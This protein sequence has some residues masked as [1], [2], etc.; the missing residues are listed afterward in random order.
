[1]SK[2]HNQLLQI[3]DV[4]DQIMMQ[5]RILWAKHH[6]TRTKHLKQLRDSGKTGKEY[7]DAV[8]QFDKL[9]AGGLW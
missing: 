7:S 9:F 4:N 6:D 1:M 8:V 3:N 5:R 2:L